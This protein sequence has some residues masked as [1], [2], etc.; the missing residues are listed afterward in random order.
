[1][2]LNGLI[3]DVILGSFDRKG[4]FDPERIFISIRIDPVH[5]FVGY[6]EQTFL[7]S[8]HRDRGALHRFVLIGSHKFHCVRIIPGKAHHFTGGTVF[9]R[10]AE[11]HVSSLMNR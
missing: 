3:M 6:D 11:Y 4:P 1:M 5:S 2:V 10:Q 9:I 7:P 8:P